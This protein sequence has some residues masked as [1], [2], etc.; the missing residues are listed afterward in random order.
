MVLIFWFQTATSLNIGAQIVT[1]SDHNLR[2]ELK[3]GVASGS[4]VEKVKELLEKVA[5]ENERVH[6]EPPPFVLFEDF[7]DN[8]L[9][10]TLF[11]WAR[12]TLPLDLRRISSAL[13]FQIDA[14]LREHGVVIAFPQRDVYLNSLHPIEVRITE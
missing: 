4:P 7:G 1:L 12:V 9:I 3:V 13:R 8:A 5:L 2:G 10:F 6:K 11:F 14:L